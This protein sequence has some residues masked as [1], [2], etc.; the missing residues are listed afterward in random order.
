MSISP[1]RHVP[2]AGS[3]P[4]VTYWR[5]KLT[6]AAFRLTA[7]CDWQAVA[8][9]CDGVFYPGEGE[10][11]RAWIAVVTEDG[12]ARAHEGD[13]IVRGTRRFMVWSHAEFAEAYDPAE[14][15]AEHRE[16]V[17]DMDPETTEQ[18]R[19]GVQERDDTGDG[20]DS[21]DGATDED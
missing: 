16:E 6:L 5:P 19:D 3:P 1:S 10:R 14:P 20:E 13:W 9:W 8:G 12:I 18:A 7:G 4:G 2:F 17:S 15:P 21:L 11:D